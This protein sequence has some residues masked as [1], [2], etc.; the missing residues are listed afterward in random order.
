ME[1]SCWR[2]FTGQPNDVIG[3]SLVS[4]SC[5]D[6]DGLGATGGYQ[7]STAR[8]STTADGSDKLA[9]SKWYLAV[10]SWNCQRSGA[11][12]P[13]FSGRN[14]SSLSDGVGLV[15]SG[16]IPRPVLVS[17]NLHRSARMERPAYSAASRRGGLGVGSFYQWP[18]RRHSQG[19]AMIRPP[20]T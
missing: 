19:V 11:H 8:V 16:G 17:E 14:F 6:H 2:H 18:E 7:P 10:S 5:A 1:F 20:M 12:Q 4:T 15:R 9:E 3:P 13:G